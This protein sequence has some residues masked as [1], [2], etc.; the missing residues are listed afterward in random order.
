M[1]AKTRKGM[2]RTLH[3]LL[4]GMPI[5]LLVFHW[6]SKSHGHDFLQFDRMTHSYVSTEDTPKKEG[7]PQIL[8]WAAK[9]SLAYNSIWRCSLTFKDSGVKNMFLV[10]PSE[11]NQLNVTEFK[12]RLGSWALEKW[13]NFTSKRW[14]LGFLRCE[15]YESK[16]SGSEWS[17]YVKSKWWV[18]P[19]RRVCI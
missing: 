6:Q 16:V 5:T 15:A 13:Q 14:K 2:W 17:C 12:K 8:R 4:K 1:I 3:W 18:F 11:R 9:V 7:W 19:L 10:V